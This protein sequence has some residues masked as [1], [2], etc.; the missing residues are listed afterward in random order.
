[1]NEAIFSLSSFEQQVDQRLRARCGIELAGL[2][3]RRILTVAFANGSSID[4][5]LS[6]LIERFDLPTRPARQPVAT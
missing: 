2:G 3:A 4:T 6:E 1:M 5:V